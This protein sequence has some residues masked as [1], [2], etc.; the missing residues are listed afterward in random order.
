[1]FKLISIF[2]VTLITPNVSLAQ[3]SLDWNLGTVV[4]QSPVEQS[5]QEKP[6]ERWE[7]KGDLFRDYKIAHAACKV[8][9]DY[10]GK[11][12]KERFQLERMLLYL[13]LCKIRD[14]GTNF[15]PC[16]DHQEYNISMVL[17]G[18]NAGF[19]NFE[20]RKFFSSDFTALLP[21]MDGSA[22]S[23]KVGNLLISCR[24]GEAPLLSVK[25]EHYYPEFPAGDNRIFAVLDDRIISIGFMQEKADV[26]EFVID[27]SEMAGELLNAFSR[28]LSLDSPVLE[29]FSQADENVSLKLSMMSLWTNY[30]AIRNQAAIRSNIQDLMAACS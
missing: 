9:S 30:V 2:A 4:E 29:I 20:G 17:D 1:M 28:D 22:L 7:P 24:P 19:D 14:A 25:M 27:G 16:S 10:E 8:D 23:E 5:V 11:D 18:F 13:G 26:G 3:T 21:Q 12:C 15:T 6:I